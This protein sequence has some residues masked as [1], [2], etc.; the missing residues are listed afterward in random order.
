MGGRAYTL[1]VVPSFGAPPGRAVITIIAIDPEGY[2][3]N[4]SFVLDVI[5]S[6]NTPPSFTTTD[7]TFT[8]QDVT[9]STSTVYHFGVTD[10][11]ILKQNLLVTATSSNANVVPND[12]ANL[13]I[14]AIAASGNGTITITPLPFLHP[15][16]VFPRPPP[17]PCP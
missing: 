4:T 9:A 15:P 11:Q 14:S 1:K 12:S 3:T 13:A 17:S 5:A 7:G 8:E 6:T 2:R 16:L 10:V